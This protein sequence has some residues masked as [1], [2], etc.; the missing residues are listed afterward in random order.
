MQ[1]K[2]NNK[3]TYVI[4]KGVPSLLGTP[5]LRHLRPS[6]LPRA[7]SMIIP[8]VRSRGRVGRRKAGARPLKNFL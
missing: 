6:I 4:R 3:L 2:E 7:P 5:F 8:G 1:I